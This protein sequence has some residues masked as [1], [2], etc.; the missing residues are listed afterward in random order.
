MM[1]VAEMLEVAA[2][3][4]G[5]FEANKPMSEGASLSLGTLF[6]FWGS[7]NKAVLNLN[8]FNGKDGDVLV[9]YN[10]G[11][12]GSMGSSTEDL[13]NVLMRKASRRIAYTK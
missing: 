8:I 12:S 2:V 6:G 5:T 7:T 4:M 11:I 1:E 9:N 3:V 13:V 10:K